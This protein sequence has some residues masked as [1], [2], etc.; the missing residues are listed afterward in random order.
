[1]VPG[2]RDLGRADEVEVVVGEVVD[3]VR[4]GAR[5]PVPAMISG[6]TSTGGIIIWKPLAIAFCAASCS[7]PSCSMA[8]KPVRK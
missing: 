4:V 3:L 1:M 7:I 6:R 2:Q 8:P 5:N